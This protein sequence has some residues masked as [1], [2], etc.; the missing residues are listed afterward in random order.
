MLA[1]YI[2]LKV[3]NSKNQNYNYQG[4]VVINSFEF[5]ESKILN[6]TG[7]IIRILS[8]SHNA[9]Y[10]FFFTDH[11]LMFLYKVFLSI[12]GKMLRI[13]SKTDNIYINCTHFHL[14]YFL[15]ISPVTCFVRIYLQLK[16]SLHLFCQQLIVPRKKSAL[17]STGQIQVILDSSNFDI[18]QFLISGSEITVPNFFHMFTLDIFFCLYT[19]AR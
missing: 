7:Y 11:L 14:F 19:Y 2:T 5:F 6:V 13:N 15:L 18:S 12:L 9:Y 10:Y 4:E 3:C 16:W 17:A 1:L 8:N